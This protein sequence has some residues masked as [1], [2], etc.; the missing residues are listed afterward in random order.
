MR[1]IVN[2]RDALAIAC[3]TLCETFEKARYFTL[4]IKT[5][6]KRTLPQ[7][8]ISHRWYALVSRI[9]K[10]YDPE[11]VKCLCKWH[12]GVP[13]LRA[14]DEEYNQICVEVLDPL[15]YEARIKAMKY[16]PVTSLFNTEQFTEYLEAVQRNYAGRVLL[17][18]EEE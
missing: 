5:G 17:T 9:E 13:I 7:N 11:E 4:D 8:A 14:D 16:F 12:K 10:E 2:S 1:L 6:K 15:P 3:A 18:F